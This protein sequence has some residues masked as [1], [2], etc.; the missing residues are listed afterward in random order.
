MEKSAL[1]P[2]AVKMEGDVTRCQGD[3]CVDLDGQESSVSQVTS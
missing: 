1:R 2:A 3:V